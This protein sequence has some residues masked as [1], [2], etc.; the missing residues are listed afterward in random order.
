LNPMTTQVFWIHPGFIQ[1]PSHPQKKML[2]LEQIIV[3]NLTKKSWSQSPKAEE[4]IKCDLSSSKG[5]FC[6][7]GTIYDLAYTT[8]FVVPY[9]KMEHALIVTTHFYS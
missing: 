7:K 4:R 3:T 2:K 8:S 6:W 9:I 1:T 5:C